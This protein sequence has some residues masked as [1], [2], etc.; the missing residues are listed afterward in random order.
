PEDLRRR[1]QVGKDIDERTRVETSGHSGSGEKRRAES[2]GRRADAVC[3]LSAGKAALEAI[4]RRRRRWIEAWECGTHLASGQAK[5]GAGAGTA[6]GA[7]EVLGSRGGAL[8]TDSGG[9]ASSEARTNW[10]CIPRHCAAGCWRRVCGT[11]RG[12]GAHTGSG[13][14]AERTSENWCR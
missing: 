11:Q 4:P 3:Q 14:N 13:G 8:R 2:G 12:G 5:E 1:L 6:T 7:E 10:W 9:R